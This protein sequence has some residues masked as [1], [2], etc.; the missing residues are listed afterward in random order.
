MAQTLTKT[1]VYIVCP[2]CGAKVPIAYSSGR[3]PLGYNV[4]FIYDTLRRLRSIQGAAK[5]LGCS[6]G[7]IYKVLKDQ[8]VTLEQ[9]LNQKV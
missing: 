1:K 9:L 2:R 6:R 8:G 4:N 7:Y 5:E 3:K